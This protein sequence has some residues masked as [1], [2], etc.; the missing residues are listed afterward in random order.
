M[1]G[2]VQ[3]LSGIGARQPLTSRRRRLRSAAWGFSDA[4]TSFH[5]NCACSEM[6]L[7]HGRCRRSRE[8]HQPCVRLIEARP[9][10]RDISQPTKTVGRP[11]LK[12][13]LPLGDRA[14][15]IF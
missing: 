1:Y 5:E 7:A 4:H 9:Q 2:S 12:A 3:T 10:T 15:L 6:R 8:V 11:S 13:G 14:S